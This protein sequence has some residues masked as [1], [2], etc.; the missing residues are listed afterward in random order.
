M[1]TPNDIA[2]KKFEKGMGGYK[3]HDVEAFMS[4]VSDTVIDLLK[5]KAD[6]EQKLELLADKLQEYRQD[7]D[8]L[9]TALL[10]AQKLGDGV[11]RE[12]KTKA[13][14][15]MRDATIKAERM[16]DNAQAQIE[17]E[18]ANLAKM[19][20]EVSAFK[21]RLLALYKQHLS[22]ITALPEVEGKIEDEPAEDDIKVAKNFKQAATPAPAEDEPIRPKAVMQQREA[23]YEDEDEEAEPITSYKKPEGKLV[24]MTKHDQ[25]EEDEEPFEEPKQESRFGPLKFGTGYELTRDEQSAPKKKR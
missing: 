25:E 5:E 17:K 23:E 7:E 3:V 8:S 24:F 22:L 6:L 2:N 15:M 1:L 12:S 4:Q 10:G 9:R 20:A 21:S 16:I 18:K 19:Q 13:E 14:I 11:I